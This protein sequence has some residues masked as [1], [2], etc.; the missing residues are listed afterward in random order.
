VPGVSD[1]DAASWLLD[2]FGADFVNSEGSTMGKDGEI[3]LWCNLE[4]MVET[5]PKIQPLEITV[6]GAQTGVD[7]RSFQRSSLSVAGRGE[8]PLRP[9]TDQQQATRGGA[10]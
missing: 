7:A 8:F 9:A 5:G 1:G 2:F 4:T 3:G 10:P 6:P